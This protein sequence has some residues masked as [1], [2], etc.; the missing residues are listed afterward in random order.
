MRKPRELSNTF[1][2]KGT[3][4]NVHIV[5]NRHETPVAKVHVLYR[6]GW[7]FIYK[8][9]HKK[10]GA[11]FWEMI[12]KSRVREGVVNNEHQAKRENL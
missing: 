4:R 3:C 6:D 8:G 11:G 9:I 10:D 5:N 2:R 12:H 1:V 7:M